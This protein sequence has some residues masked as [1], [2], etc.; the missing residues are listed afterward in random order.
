ML[1]DHKDSQ[2]YIQ[3]FKK[4]FNNFA[5]KAP[6]HIS[7]TSTPTG[8]TVV[9]LDSNNVYDF[10]WDFSLPIKTF[11]HGI[12]EILAKDC[13]PIIHKVEL[14]EIAISE[15]EQLFMI[16]NG[17]NLDTLPVKRYTKEITPFL[18]DKVIVFKDLLIIKNL[19]T[20]E[21]FRY[22]MNKSCIYFLKKVRSKRLNKEQAA[23]YFFKNS[24]LLN[25]II[26]RE[27][28]EPSFDEAGEDNG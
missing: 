13:Y 26:L 11:I 28:R 25:K 20:E 5:E 17:T 8:V 18:I 24:V 7:Y 14:K 6:I 27:D 15:E 22:K 12:K 1:H 9:D 4:R 2:L 16:E 21:C 3:L 10:T 23:D 19:L